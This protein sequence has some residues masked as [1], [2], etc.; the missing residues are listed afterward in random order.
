MLFV[1]WVRNLQQM[2]WTRVKGPACLTSIFKRNLSQTYLCWNPKIGQLDLALVRQQDVG[3][4]DVSVHL[5][6]GVE[7]G[8][9]LQGLAAHEGDLLLCQGTRD[10]KTKVIWW[11]TT[12]RHKNLDTLAFSGKTNLTSPNQSSH[13][14]RP[15]NS[16]LAFIFKTLIFGNVA[17][18]PASKWVI[19][20]IVEFKQ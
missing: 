11:I 19:L 8:Q 17:S 18:S 6:H 5:S 14:R 12:W 13:R 10:W 15:D 20:P 16:K 3:A 1:I 4:L 7:V 9:A 2:N